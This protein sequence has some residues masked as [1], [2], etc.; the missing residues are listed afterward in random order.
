MATK[1]MNMPQ[2]I[3]LNS[4]AMKKLVSLLSVGQTSKQKKAL[5]QAR[6]TYSYYKEK[7]Q[8]NASN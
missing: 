2:E 5:K 4:S 8:K 7:W 1:E 6:G 3:V